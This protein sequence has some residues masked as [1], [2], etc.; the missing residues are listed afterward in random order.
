METNFRFIQLADPQFGQFAHFSGMSD[1]Q[2]MTYKRSNLKVDKESKYYHLENETKLFSKAISIA[3]E[4][5]VSFVVVCGDM[6]NTPGDREQVN[7]VKTISKNLEANIPIFWVPGNHDVGADTEVPTIESLNQYRKEFGKDYFSFTNNGYKFLVI[8]SVV[9]AHPEL[10]IEEYL[11]QMK[12]IEEEMNEAKDK[13]TPTVVFTH[14]PLFLDNAN[15]KPMEPE[16][17]PSPP[18]K[19]GYWTIPNPTRSDLIDLF[20]VG[21]VQAV[22][23]G[24]W[25][26]NSYARNGK[27]EM[28]TSGPV[29]YPLGEDPSGYRIVKINNNQISHSYHKL[30][31]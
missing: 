1:H 19:A 29:G 7:A 26:R 11:D 16:W 20:E 8:N 30:N 28:I 2:I 25:H 27:M 13:K 15:E 21:N 6:V 14:H 12:F 3:N 5:G 10:V 23:A 22:F 17:A 18:G 9:L 24:H 31:Q 4:L